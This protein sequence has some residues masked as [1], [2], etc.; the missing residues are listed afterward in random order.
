[1]ENILNGAKNFMLFIENNW[2]AIIVVLSV[3]FLIYKKSVRFFSMSEE[4][5]IETAKGV[6]RTTMLNYVSKAE[7]NYAEWVRAGA[8][9]RAE[10]ISA[11]YADFPILN[12]VTDQNALI[13]WVDTVIDEALKE[14][15]KMISEKE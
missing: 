13:E 10:V 12:K 4:E 14:M 1:M 9:K 15:R 8:A 7:Q 2:T 3:G 11:V 5:Q 6:I